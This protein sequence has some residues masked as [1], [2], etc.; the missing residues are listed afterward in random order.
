MSRRDD[1]AIPRLR[2]RIQRTFEPRDVALAV[3]GARHPYRIALPAD[4]DAPLN[5]LAAQRLRRPP[6]AA[7]SPAAEAARDAVASGAFLPYW[8]L[9]WPSGLALAEAILGMPEATRGRRVLELG[10]GLGVTA[11]A[12][13]ETGAHLA[14]ADAFADALLFCRYNALRNTG[15]APRTLLLNWRTE[16]GRAA[17]RALAPLDVVLAADVL[18]EQDD[19]APLLAL[20]PELLRP[21]G[22]FWLAEP[23]R[24]VSEA[25]VRLATQSGWRDEPATYE[26]VWPTETRPVRVTVHRMTRATG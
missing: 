12:A 9:L 5:E 18:Y 20:I 1:Q 23:G 17:C 11:T 8:A 6:R 19:I 4:P 13:I 14:A 15:H 22:I 25:L 26:R 7:Q 24:R 3:P 16:P 10:S 2:A 21:G